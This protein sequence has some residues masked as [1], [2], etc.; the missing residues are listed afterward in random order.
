MSSGQKR[1]RYIT[2]IFCW[3]ALNWPNNCVGQIVCRENRVLARRK[4]Q[5][6]RPILMSPQKLQDCVM[7]KPEG[8]GI[9]RKAA[10]TGFSYIGVDG[11]PVRDAEE[12]KRIRSLVIPPAWSNVWICPL[13]NGHIQAVG[14]DARGRKQYRYHP[15]Y[16]QVRDATKFVRMAAFGE[17]LP[18]HPQ[19]GGT[20]SGVGGTARVGRCWPL[21]SDCWKKPASGWAMRSMSRRTILTG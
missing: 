5:S 1:K 21:W 9:V 14:R 15:L 13:K 11:K 17:A 10:G 7:C 6:Y 4:Q 20:R 8:P 12:L 18:S 19:A 3:S 16:R 2:I